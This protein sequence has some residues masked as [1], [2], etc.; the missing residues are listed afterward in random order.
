MSTSPDLAAV[1]AAEVV[2]AEKAV[3]A[4]VK[5]NTDQVKL[6]WRDEI[7][8]AG[9]G[10]RLAN[11]VRGR[12]FPSGEP[13]LSA[14]GLVYVQPA[15]RVST[16]RRASAAEIVLAH[17]QG[18]TI[19]SPNGFW[20]AIPTPAAGR[21]R[22]N[23]KMTPAEWEQRHGVRLRFIYRGAG[24]PGLLVADGARLRAT[25]VA[26]R[27][28]SRTGR[29]QATVPIFIL[30]PQVT[31]PRRIGDLYGIAE[32]LFGGLPRDVIGAWVDER[33]GA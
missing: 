28:R 24:R 11:A 22:R 33:I 25:G 5:A 17:M 12:T 21:G 29:G 20:L 16:S 13:S 9:F 18:V 15:P 31:L 14:A 30:V 19:R 4:G 10:N 7:R 23:A 8:R 2:A 3:T 32:D 1:F 27:S 26:A 6:A